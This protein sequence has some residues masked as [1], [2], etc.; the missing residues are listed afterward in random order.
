MCA[1]RYGYITTTPK[2][3][4]RNKDIVGPFRSFGVPIGFDT[5]VNAPAVSEM[6]YGGH[7]Y[8]NDLIAMSIELFGFSR[9]SVW[10]LTTMMF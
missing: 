8:A 10:I 3:V 1:N 7:G 6:L 2:I 9:G 4:W 5:D